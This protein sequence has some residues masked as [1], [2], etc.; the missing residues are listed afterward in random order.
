MVYKNNSAKSI[1]MYRYEN[2]TTR[3]SGL[4]VFAKSN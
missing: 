1:K 2:A 3:K 4:Y